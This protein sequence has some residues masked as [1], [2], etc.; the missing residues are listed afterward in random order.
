[1]AA[2]V[3]TSL[4]RKLATEKGLTAASLSRAANLGYSTVY[5]VW[6][7]ATPKPNLQTIE[8]I[9]RVLGVKTTDLIEEYTEENSLAL[10]LPARA[11]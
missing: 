8:A 9:A 2:R 6:D 7:G 10:P 11:A 4:L 3:N 1:M 5:K